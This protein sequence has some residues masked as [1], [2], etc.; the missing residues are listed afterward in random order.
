[1]VSSSAESAPRRSCAVQERPALRSKAGIWFQVCV[2]AS[3]GHMSLG[4]RVGLV[5][6][7]ELN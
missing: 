6:V 1:M 4:V 5:V 3:P 7:S 2:K